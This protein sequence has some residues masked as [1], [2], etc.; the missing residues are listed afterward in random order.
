[1]ISDAVK[2]VMTDS[3]LLGVALFGLGYLVRQA[4]EAFV[5]VSAE[6]REWRRLG[7]G[8]KRARA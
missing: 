1:M 8:A 7:G 2:A 5:R 3:P 6:R 4:A